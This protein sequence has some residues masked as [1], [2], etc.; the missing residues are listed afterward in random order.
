MKKKLALISILG[1]ILLIII[2]LS[3]KN[4]FLIA[5]FIAFLVVEIFVYRFLIKSKPKYEKILTTLVVIL[6]LIILAI[7]ISLF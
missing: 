3:L 6:D 1:I 4:I 7:L 2:L 5:G